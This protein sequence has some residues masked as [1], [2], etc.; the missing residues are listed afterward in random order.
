MQNNFRA[1]YGRLKST[2]RRLLRA[3]TEYADTYHNQ[4]LD[5]IERGVARKLT[6]EEIDTPSVVQYIPHHEILKASSKS[7]PVRIVFN[8][9]AKF[10]GQS[11][12]DLWAKGPCMMN[13]LYSILLRFRQHL[14]GIA[15]DI[16]KMY[17]TIKLSEEDQQVQRFLWRDLN[18]NAEPDHYCLTTVSYGGRPAAA[19]AG[20]ALTKTTEMSKEEFP[21]VNKLIKDDIFVDDMTT[22]TDKREDATQLMLDTESVLEM[23]GFK[24]K[25]WITSGSKG[26]HNVNKSTLC[27]EEKILGML[28]NPEEDNFRF[29]ICINFEAK[30]KKQKGEHPETSEINNIVPTLLTRR[31][32]LSQIARIYD[33]LGLITPVTLGAKVL[34]RNLCIKNDSK[35]GKWDTP[36]DEELREEAIQLFDNILNV[37]MIRFPRCVKPRRYTGNPTLVVFSDGSDSAYGAVTYIRWEVTDGIFEANLLTSKNRIATRKKL[38]TPP[39]GI[40]WFSHW[41]SSSKNHCRKNGFYIRQNY[42][43]CRFKYCTGS[44]SEGKLRVCHVCCNQNR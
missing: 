14:I 2:E 32:I 29:E 27:G 12:N 3:G 7:T 26:S 25:E 33:P 37:E 13:D 41:I 22:S 21:K 34:M 19:F 31:M 44:N 5:M 36:V 42:S 39:I 8:F 24:V 30:W 10:M 9:S 16:K 1:A 35:E 38:S 20:L 18:L 23:G 6:T 11:L 40:M 28:W 43:P 15:G 4:I 17:N